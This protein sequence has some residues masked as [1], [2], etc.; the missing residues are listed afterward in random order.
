MQT[1]FFYSVGKTSAEEE[2]EEEE[3]DIVVTDNT[4]PRKNPSPP[5]SGGN[6]NA[7]TGSKYS[8]KDDEDELHSVSLSDTEDQKRRRK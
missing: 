4:S 7:S 1:T 5:Y 3:E 8:I 2:D 6:S